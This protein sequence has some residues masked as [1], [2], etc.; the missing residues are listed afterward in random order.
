MKKFLIYLI[1][2]YQKYLSP[3]QGLLPKYLGLSRKTCIFYPTCSEYTK[4]ALEKY[5][6]FKG[7]WFGFKRILKCNPFSEPRVDKLL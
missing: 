4:Q 3:D 1:T 2:L 7:I 5:G 6:F